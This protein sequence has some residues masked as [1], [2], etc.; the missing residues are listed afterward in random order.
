V[1]R[2]NSKPQQPPAKAPAREEPDAGSASVLP[3]EVM[4]GDRFTEHGHE[5]EVLTRPEHMHG[6]RR[7][8]HAS[9]G[10]VAGDRAAGDVGRARTPRHPP[11]SPVNSL[12][13]TARVCGLCGTAFAI[14]IPPGDQETQRDRLCAACAGLPAPPPGRDDA[15]PA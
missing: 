13:A 14:L 1:K 11:Q 10:P 7:Y 5:W 12:R 6:E 4:V 3:I 8:G 9:R 15:D 2:K